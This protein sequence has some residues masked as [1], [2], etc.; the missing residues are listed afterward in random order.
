M[1]VNFDNYARQ[2]NSGG[3][4]DQ[5]QWRVFVKDTESVLD[6]IERVTYLLHPTFVNPLRVIKDR[7]NKFE[8]VSI[9][10]GEFEIEITIKFKEGNETKQVYSVDLEK[11]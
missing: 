8:L 2:I 9:G 5:Y 6:S 7:E 11:D 3:D 4:T 1:T 10:W